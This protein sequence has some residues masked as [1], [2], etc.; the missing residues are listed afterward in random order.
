MER[1]SGKYTGG[2]TGMD[3]RPAENRSWRNNP[4]PTYHVRN[5]EI[6]E[7]RPED[8]IEEERVPNTES[9]NEGR[10]RL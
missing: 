3:S 9:G 2:N 5:M 4:Q 10:P 1:S 7:M 6:E 8:E